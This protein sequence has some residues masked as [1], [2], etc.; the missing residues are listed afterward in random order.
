MRQFITIVESLEEDCVE[1]D[2]IKKGTYTEWRDLDGIF[3]VHPASNSEYGNF[4][5]QEEAEEY[6]ESLGGK[7]H[8]VR[9]GKLK[10][11]S[12]EE[13]KQ[14]YEIRHQRIKWGFYV[15]PN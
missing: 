12:D 6:A 9:R 13:A 7:W 10:T 5:E 15:E 14:D 8:V 4:C 1:H 11:M 2:R 3:V